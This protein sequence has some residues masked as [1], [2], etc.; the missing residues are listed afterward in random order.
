[1]RGF[2]R[3][4]HLWGVEDRETMR[5][6]LRNPPEQ[7]F[8][9]W[10]DGTF[11]RLAEDTVRRIVYVA[12]IW[13][14]LQMRLLRC[15]A[16]GRLGAAAQHVISAAIRRWSEWRRATSTDLAA[17]RAYVDAARAPWS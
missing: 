14:A 5:R 12:G 16:R 15:P 17:V 6:V 10:R 4:M 11:S 3:I 13:K 2:F 1:M 9:A 7:M 8:Y